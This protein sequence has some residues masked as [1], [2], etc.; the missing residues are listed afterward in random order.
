MPTA[1]APAR[2]NLI[3]EHT[4]YNSGFVL[5]T[6][7]PFQ[8]AVSVEEI[9]GNAGD[10]KISSGNFPGLFDRRADDAC[11]DHWT[12]YIVGCLQAL[13]QRGI[14]IPPLKLHVDSTIPMGAGISSSAALSVATLRVLRELLCLELDDEDIGLLAHKAE[15]DF[16]GVPCGMMDQFVSSLGKPGFAFLFDTQAVTYRHVPLPAGL[17][18]MLV[19]CGKSH[20]LAD[21]DGYR[22][23]VA[24]CNEACRLLG[25]HTL[26]ELGPGDLE[27][28][29]QLP[30]PLNR[31]ARHVITE[32]A[33]V[34]DSVTALEQ[35]DTGRL[36]DLMAASHVSQRDDYEV[37]IPE[38]DRLVESSNQ[39]GIKACRLTGGGFGGSI[40]AL[41]PHA[42]TDTWWKYLAA[43]NPE[44]ILVST[45]A[46]TLS[47]M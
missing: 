30:E 27:R 23:R 19:N 12:D 7:L 16:V 36:A 42:Q 22:R 4:D 45:Y 1:Y 33:R 21:G 11:Q 25:V 8:T 47:Q 28:V 34:L 39:F 43:E 31:R 9:T 38:I 2:A 13:K 6:V 44:S 35:H 14:A 10:V 29:A 37:S 46:V 32:N 5:P 18:I 20:S 15:H 41:V 17:E 40:V 3:G 26:R 24:E